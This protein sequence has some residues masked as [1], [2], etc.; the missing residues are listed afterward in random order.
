MVHQ[1]RQMH[2]VLGPSSNMS[3]KRAKGE[4]ASG[5]SPVDPAYK[6][7]RHGPAD[8]ENEGGQSP[9]GSVSS[10]KKSRVVTDDRRKGKAEHKRFHNAIDKLRK[11]DPECDSKCSHTCLNL[12]HFAETVSCVCVCA[13]LWT[14]GMQLWCSGRGRRGWDQLQS[15]N[16]DGAVFKCRYV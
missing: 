16:S 6:K 10:T 14:S 12:V 1:P 9:Q 4:M 5:A 7:N 3:G 11:T 13:K 8:Q 15:Q 2:R